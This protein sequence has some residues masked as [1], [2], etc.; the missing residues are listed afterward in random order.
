MNDLYQRV[1]YGSAVHVGP[2]PGQAADRGGLRM[3]R[4]SGR[5]S[6]VQ[7][8]PGATSLWIVLGGRV[9]VETA[10][11]VFRLQA[12]QGL[13][14]TPETGARGQLRGS[15]DVLV[16]AMPPATLAR[17]MR[18]ALPSGVAPTLFPL[19]QRLSRSML[20]AAVALVRAS[21]AGEAAAPQRA[22]RQQMLVQDLVLATIEH[23]AMVGEWL[24]RAYGRTEGHR[25][26][27]LMRLLR[28]RN[29]ILNAPFAKH[30]IE[31]LAL[32]ARYSKSHFIRLF[33]DVFGMTPHDLLTE[34]RIDLAKHLITS[35]RLAISEV[36][37]NVGFDSRCAFS[38]LFK[39]R[40]GISAQDYRRLAQDGDLP[41]AA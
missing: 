27:V 11:G 30:E 15:A 6:Q 4:A 29:R 7:V 22:A 24:Q 21:E 17:L 19:R 1:G 8:A 41:A 2:E 35:S 13:V 18:G 28:A 33:R 10:D 3:V 9:E 37:S 38:R 34:A 32:A 40:V 14:V 5:G 31:T 12:R 23:Q 36:A 20:R 26:R 39:R 16:L 25:R